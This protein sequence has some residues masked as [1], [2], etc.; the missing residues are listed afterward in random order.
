[1]C[2][3]SA[4]GALALLVTIILMPSLA[5]GG[6][7]TS[8]AKTP[9]SLQFS[10]ATYSVVENGGSVTVA[11]TRTGGSEGEVTVQYAIGADTATAGADYTATSAT[12]IFASGD[13]SDKTF[14]LN[15]NDDD[16][17]EGDETV[18]LTLK[19]PTGTAILG[20]P[21]TAALTITDDDLGDVTEDG[22]VDLL[23]LKLVVTNFGSPPFDDPRADANGDGVVDVF[24]LALVAHDLGRLAPRPLRPM[25]VKRTF[26]NLTFQRLTNLVQ[27]DDGHDHIFVTEQA[28]RIR[29]FPNDQQ[30]TEAAI[31]MDISDRVSEASNEEGL[32]GLAFDPGYR[33][34]GYFYV[35]YSAA[36]PRRSVLSRFSVSQDD[37][38]SADPNSESIIMEIPQPF[39][40]HNGGQLAF[41]LDGYLYIGLGDG[42]AGGDPRG[43]GQNVGTLL[44]SIL[45]IDVSGG[46]SSR[47]P[48]DNPFVG[49]EGARKEIWAYGLRNP[50][51][52]SFDEHTGL[53]W[54]ADVGQSRWEEIDIVKVGLN[55]GWNIMEGPHCFSTST[56][57]DK[58]G[59]ELPLWEYDHSDGCSITGGY[60]YRGRGT[61]SL[62]GA[63]VYG[64]YCSGKIW[65]LRYDG[66]IVTEQMLLIDSEVLITS[67]GQDLA[68]NLYI[69]SRSEGIY[70]LA[71]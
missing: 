9:F 11:V 39:P 40:N 62:L 22:F 18:N 63:Y 30:T 37:P 66:N 61:P 32:L 48:P 42:G 35:Y 8:T 55:Y 41:G 46:K 36:N 20:S 59:L 33:D 17:V 28:G 6:R 10:A 69:L 16:L 2:R 38:N 5:A 64:D 54:V 67:F 15:I 52:F 25:R 50:W 56:N 53:L 3:A 57:C 65:G 27:P 44:A 13:P 47:V 7:D 12:L 4:R 71:P 19:N 34:N 43:N 31:F 26:P 60:V 51:R 23:D 45:R 29:V 1:M 14:T 49:V 58:T 24:D 68:R 70:Y 21:S